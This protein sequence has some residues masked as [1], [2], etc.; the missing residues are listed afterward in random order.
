MTEYTANPHQDFESLEDLSDFLDE[1]NIHSNCVLRFFQL[2]QHRSETV[3]QQTRNFVLSTNQSV[4]S[5][6]SAPLICLLQEPYYHKQGSFYSPD[7]QYASP[8]HLKNVVFQPE[9][10]IIWCPNIQPPTD[11]PTNAK[12]YSCCSNNGGQ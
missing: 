11:L 7:S 5:L 6:D 8:T 3:D 1:A 10:Q 2:N 4:H 9:Q 12:R